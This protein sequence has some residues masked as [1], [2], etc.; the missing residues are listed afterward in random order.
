MNKIKINKILFNL[1]IKTPL[2]VMILLVVVG[3]NFYFLL[4][5][6]K[7]RNYQKIT[8]ALIKD[9]QGK[10]W[11]AAHPKPVFQKV[12]VVGKAIVWFISG[13]QVRYDGIVA[14]CNLKSQPGN[15]LIEINQS[16]LQ[17]LFTQKNPKPQIIIEFL[18]L[19]T[20]SK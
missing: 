19:Q 14:K 8:G 6:V 9:N 7:S 2:L 3:M 12:L 4:T 16:K 17:K 13:E 20:G 1:T 15:I 10:V 11:I 5:E 18:A